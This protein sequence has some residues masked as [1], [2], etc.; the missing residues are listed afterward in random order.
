MDRR[1]LKR[2]L[3]WIIAREQ[4]MQCRAQA[5]NVRSFRCLR[6]AILFGWSIAI[7]AERGSIFLLT[8]LEMAR[9]AEIN[10]V[11]MVAGRDHDIGGLEI[12]KNNRWLTRVQIIQDRAQL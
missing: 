7:G 12:A 8:W 2:R 11:D 4:L 3:G 5:I 10:Q 1:E 9:D 6:L